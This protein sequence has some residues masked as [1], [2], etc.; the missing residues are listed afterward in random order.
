[1]VR[2]TSRF[3]L[4]FDFFGLNDNYR[5][6]LFT[7]IDEIVTYGNNYDWSTIYN[8]PIWLRRFTYKK[9]EERLKKQQ[10]SV[11]NDITE[12]TNISRFPKSEN[13]YTTNVSK[14]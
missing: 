7:E 11:S 8:F 3:P 5:I 4:T 12:T 14:K 2:R 1:M 9:I 10:E 6:Q 13:N